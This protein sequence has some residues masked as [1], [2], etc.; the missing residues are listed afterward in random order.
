MHNWE[1]SNRN[2]TTK[3]KKNLT[4]FGNPHRLNGNGHYIPHKPLYNNGPNSIVVGTKI[5]YQKTIVMTI[6]LDT[7]FGI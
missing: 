1:P 2:L 3:L 5:L 6:R 4:K 7:E